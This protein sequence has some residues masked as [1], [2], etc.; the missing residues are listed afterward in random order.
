M[1]EIA[2]PLPACPACGSPTGAPCVETCEA[3]R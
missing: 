3:N 1:T 2:A